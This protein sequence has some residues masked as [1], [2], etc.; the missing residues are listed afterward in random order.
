MLSLQN[1]QKDSS[2]FWTFLAKIVCLTVTFRTL[3]VHFMKKNKKKKRKNI[4]ISKESILD[5]LKEAG[6]PLFM[7][8]IVHFLHTPPEQKQIVKRL[9][10]DL[11]RK[12]QVILLKGN[13]Y[14]LTRQMKL[15]TG[16]LTVHPDGFGFVQPEEPEQPDVFIPPRKLKG[17]VHGDLVTARIERDSPKGPEGAVIRIIE[18]KVKE[19]VGIFH[20]GKN[21]GV[22]IPEN[23]RLHTEILIPNPKK[24]GEIDGQ[25]VIA[26]ILH[27]S[28]TGTTAEGEIIKVLGDP[29]DIEVQSRIVI[30]KYQ[31]PHEFSKKAKIQA[32][33]IPARV[34]ENDLS[35]RKDIRQLPLVTI[36]GEDARDFDDAVHVKKTAKSF[37]LTVAIA[38]V[39]HYVEKNSPLDVDAVQRGTSVYF[40]DRVI[41]MLPER[42]SNGICSLVPDEDRLAMVAKI[43]FDH[44]GE[45]RKSTFFKA[46]IKSHQRFTYKK[47]QRLLDGRDKDLH[48]KYSRFIKTLNQMAELAKLLMDKRRQR[49]SIDFDLPESEVIL[50]LTGELEAIV[51]RERSMAH[52]L[53]EEFMIAANEAVARFL[54]QRSIPTLYRIHEPPE[55]EKIEDL[56]GF[57]RSLGHNVKAPKKI[58]PFWCQ[59]IL[60]MVEGRPEEYV[61]NSMLLRTMN[62]AVYSPENKGHFGLA[63]PT[64]LHFTSP[65]R[66]YPDLI[67][68]RVLK[69]NLRRVRKRQV[70]KNEELSVLGQ[71]LSQ[72][73]RNAMEA[74]REMLDRL[75]VRYMEDKIGE[76]FHGI[77]SSV[78]SFG[79]FVELK[80]I[81][82]SGLVRLVDMADDYYEF[83]GRRHILRGR[84][85]GKTYRLGQE[86]TLRLISVNKA[87][88]HINFEIIQEEK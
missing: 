84:R 19:V 22:V 50:G 26:R 46:V 13:R 15:V 7:R 77:I 49:G 68:H 83:D 20:T 54:S 53:I 41:P 27:F 71:K 28:R 51:K 62:Q 40:P 60:G 5:L 2:A 12:G 39:S 70:Y 42:L 3:I 1:Y 32:R 48:R 4:I 75:K 16:I 85:T 79:M 47:V 88:R 18:R 14:G 34:E 23:E 56:V 24:Y 52:R 81:L 74:E 64:Y 17:A 66:R 58:S 45:V 6:H 69:G 9:V 67:V 80:E 76:T 25:A 33:E 35:G 82:I 59:K 10:K 38:D 31:L 37:I 21:L 72:E 65:I 61:V 86:V 43:Y 73:E 44:S 87:R 55:R 11:L 30:N 78:T 57:L 36:D 63:S 29:N 8:E